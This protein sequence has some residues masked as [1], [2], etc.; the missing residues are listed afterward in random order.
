MFEGGRRMVDQF[1]H[2]LMVEG[3]RLMVDGDF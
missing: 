3:G 2:P 1:K